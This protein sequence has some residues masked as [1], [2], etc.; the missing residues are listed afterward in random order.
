M[1]PNAAHPP[2]TQGVNTTFFDP[3][4]HKP[5]D[6]LAARGQLAFGAPW[7][8][9]ARQAKQQ[10]QRRAAPY[11]FL[12]SF[13]FETRKARVARPV[14]CWAAAIVARQQALSARTPRPG[15]EGTAQ[16]AHPATYTY[17][18][19]CSHP[20]HQGWDILLSAYLSE[21][22]ASDAVELHLHTRPW[23]AAE[24]IR[25]QGV[26]GRGSNVWPMHTQRSAAQAGA[27]LAAHGCGCTARA[28]AH[29]RRPR[30]RAVPRLPAR[31]GGGAAER[32]RR[33]APAHCVRYRR[34]PGAAARRRRPAPVL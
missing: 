9:K 5:L 1:T 32:Q 27:L 13:K 33:G 28:L 18:L 2:R 12:S 14:L 21:F 34:P 30:C 16:N 29:A 25:K 3:A 31:L 4:R 10:A 26:R 6:D 8:N 23:D 19:T 17:K 24:D 22:T 15:G 11:R 7:A 20:T